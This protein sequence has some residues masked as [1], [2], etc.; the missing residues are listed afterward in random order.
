MSTC[1]LGLKSNFYLGGTMDE[2]NLEFT[3]IDIT[4]L[5]CY[6]NAIEDYAHLA[7]S[8]LDAMENYVLDRMTE[9]REEKHE[10]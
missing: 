1:R 10:K 4:T 9:L 7:K 8:R 2:K 6:L 5:R 3:L